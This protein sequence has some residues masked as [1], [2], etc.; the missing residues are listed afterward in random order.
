MVVMV[1]ESA[2]IRLH[3]TISDVADSECIDVAAGGGSR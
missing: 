3:A 1:D 2:T